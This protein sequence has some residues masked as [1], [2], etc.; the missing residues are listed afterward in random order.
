[1]VFWELI[2]KELY[3]DNCL[4]ERARKWAENFKPH[5]KGDENLEEFFLSWTM[6]FDDYHKALDWIEP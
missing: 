4:G 5:V 2:V 6:G 1:M 3:E